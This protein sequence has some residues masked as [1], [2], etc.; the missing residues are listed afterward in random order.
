MFTLKFVIAR[1]IHD[2]PGPIRMR[3]ARQDFLRGGRESAHYWTHIFDEANAVR[4]AKIEAAGIRLGAAA[5]D[6]QV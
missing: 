2:V 3:V 6:G 1:F 4:E 5:G